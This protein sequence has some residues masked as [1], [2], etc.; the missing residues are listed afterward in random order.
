[1]SEEK[2]NAALND[3]E[4][5]SVAGGYSYY[6]E[7]TRGPNQIICPNCLCIFDRPADGGVTCPACGY[8]DKQ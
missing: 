3:E 7:G 8:P 6:P 5:G 1:M 4:L 2:K